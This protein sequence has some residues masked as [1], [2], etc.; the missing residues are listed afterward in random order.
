MHLPCNL[1]EQDLARATGSAPLA[2]VVAAAAAAA[3]AAVAPLEAAIETPRL[4]MRYLRATDV[5]PLMPILGDPEVTRYLSYRPWASEE[6]GQLWCNEF[7]E[8]NRIGNT[9]WFVCIE[10]ASGRMVGNCVLFDNQP[11][12]RRAELGYMIGRAYWRQGFAQEASRAL[13][14]HG[15]RRCGLQRLEAQIHVDN[16]ASQ[17]LAVKLGFQREGH[18]RNRL[19]NCDGVLHDVFLYGLLQE[20][21]G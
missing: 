10:K 3:A 4:L 9:A 12:C 11:M 17:Q 8:T 21:A 7:A 6:D 2:S 16:I 13:I 18:L 15:F 5:A 1:T 19:V 14:A 20:E